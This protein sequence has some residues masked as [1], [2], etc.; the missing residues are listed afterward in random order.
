MT[1]DNDEDP[2][3]TTKKV[4]APSATKK[5]AATPSKTTRVADAKKS[6]SGARAAAESEVGIAKAKCPG[7]GVDL[8]A[9]QAESVLCATC[10]DKLKTPSRSEEHTSEL[11]SRP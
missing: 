8:D 9:E 3:P 6:S 1:D 10:S 4:G 2:K 5:V 7:C 11:Q